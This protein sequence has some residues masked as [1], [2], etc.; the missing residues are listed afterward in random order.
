MIETNHYECPNDLIFK[1]D[2]LVAQDIA[3]ISQAVAVGLVMA[4]TG[5]PGLQ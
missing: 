4:P 1:T 3:Q 5:A 2:K